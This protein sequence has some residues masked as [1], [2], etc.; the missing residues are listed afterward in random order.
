[1]P[2]HLILFPY[3]SILC[4][5]GNHSDT[6]AMSLYSYWSE[7]ER[8]SGCYFSISDSIFETFERVRKPSDDNQNRGSMS[9]AGE[10]GGNKQTF[11]GKQAGEMGLVIKTI[12]QGYTPCLIDSLLT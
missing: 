2:W 12:R 11:P 8:L 5:G 9:L 6:H 4:H 7:A 3:D 10:N 1:M